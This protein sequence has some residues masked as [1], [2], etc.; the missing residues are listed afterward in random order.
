ML[1]AHF[2][3]GVDSRVVWFFRGWFCGLLWLFLLSSVVGPIVGRTH[4]DWSVGSFLYCGRWFLVGIVFV[5]REEYSGLECA[6]LVVGVGIVTWIVVS[7]VGSAGSDGD[8]VAADFGDDVV[9]NGFLLAFVG[10]EN[11]T[12][13][14]VFDHSDRPVCVDCHGVPTWPGGVVC[15]VFGYLDDVEDQVD[16]VGDC[17]NVLFDE[18]W[19]RASEVSHLEFV[20]H[21]VEYCFHSPAGTINVV[22]V[23]SGEV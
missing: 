14:T 22:N 13:D 9:H 11:E 1:L 3:A 20:F 19:F 17:E 12:D 8:E 2:S 6:F 16:K 7:G 21:D 10:C 23:V 4:R 18:D 5:G 15:R